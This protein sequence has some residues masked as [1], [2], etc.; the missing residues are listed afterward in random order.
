VAEYDVLAVRGRFA[1]GGTL[2]VAAYGAFAAA[3]GD[4][5]DVIE[6][7]ERAGMFHEAEGLDQY[8]GVALKPVFTDT[9]L[10]LQAL[11][12]TQDGGA[13]DDDLNGT[14]GDDALVGHAGDDTLSGGLGADLLLGGDGDDALFGGAGD[15]TLVGGHGTDTADYAVST[16]AIGADL[17]AGRIADGLGGVDT[18][19]SV[20]NIVGTGHDDLIVGND[21]ANVIVGGGG[22]DT[23]TGG[24]GADVF[25]YRG[26]GE[27]GD[28]ITD[29][30][31]GEDAIRL[32]GE[33]FGL[34]GPVAAGATF[35]VIGAAYDG[36]DA[37]ANAAFAANAPTLVYSTATHALYY[38]A[39]GAEP[40]GYAILATLQPGA[41]LTAADI[42]IASAGMA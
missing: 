9:G 31:A 5:F 36:S 25:V 20:E 2:A 13:G 32:E 8:A 28:V 23:L 30:V 14:D 42:Q 41:V 15:D 38:D 33:G 6:W 10:T 1:L 35:S 4:S 40:G 18:V 39:N 3:A 16:A 7:N 21:R 27:G 24:A 17:T 37:G 22:A 19:I 12:V 26:P 29:F 34:T 11:A